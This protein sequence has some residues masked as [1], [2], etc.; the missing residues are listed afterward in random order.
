MAKVKA[1]PENLQFFFFGRFNLQ[2]AFAIHTFFNGRNT[3]SFVTLS[4]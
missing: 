1:L 2:V 4:L 3:L